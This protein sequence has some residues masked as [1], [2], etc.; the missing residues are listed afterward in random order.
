LSAQ[1]RFSAVE[2][3][4]S[5]SEMISPSRKEDRPSG[6]PMATLA[7]VTVEMSEHGSG[8]EPKAAV[9]TSIS[10]MA[11]TRYITTLYSCF[12]NRCAGMP[13]QTSLLPDDG[14]TGENRL[15]S[16]HPFARSA[17]LRVSQGL[18]ESNKQG[19]YLSI[20]QF[21]QSF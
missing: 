19:G 21:L 6:S 20:L 16:R 7:S 3:N 5:S 11:T 13:G 1:Y 2:V 17:Y 12:V 15:S 9:P 14:Q 4:V 8:V 10:A 18:E